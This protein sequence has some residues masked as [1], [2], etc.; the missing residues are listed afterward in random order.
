MIKE[1]I[2][3][4]CPIGCHIEVDTNNDYSVKGNQC[5]RG[6][7]YGKKELTSPT[8][9]VTSTMIIEG[10]IYNRIPVKTDGEIPKKLIF[11]IMKEI[12]KISLKSPVQMGD[13]IIENILNTGINVV[14]S[15][16]M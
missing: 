10:G 4:T 6:I 8:R 2:C 1:L 16:S 12:D 3:I 14:T 15:R 9:T 13:I 7:A 11:K 5:K